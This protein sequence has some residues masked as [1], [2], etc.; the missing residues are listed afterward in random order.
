MVSR[1]KYSSG[2]QYFLKSAF[3][4]FCIYPLLLIQTCFPEVNIDTSHC[5][6]CLVMFPHIS[7]DI[8]CIEN[9]C[10]S[11]FHTLGRCMSPVMAF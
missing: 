9:G 6:L 3:S 1:R 4:Q 8:H 5:A 7:L 11:T 10:R 2:I